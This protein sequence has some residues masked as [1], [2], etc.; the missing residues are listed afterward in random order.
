MNKLVKTMLTSIVIILLIGGVALVI[1]YN[2]DH[3]KITSA[4]S[5][6]IDKVIEYSYETPEITTDLE[7]GSFVRIQFQVLT[8]SK[9]AK[10]EIEKRDFQLKNI[11]IKALAVLDRDDFKSGLTELEGNMV[12]ELN[13]VMTK[14]NV[15]DVYTIN[16]VLQ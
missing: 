14:G 1:V 5:H 9:Q 3:E 2:Q 15:I 8:D 13:E 10:E 7:D 11:L 6:S 12:T 4:E 16:K